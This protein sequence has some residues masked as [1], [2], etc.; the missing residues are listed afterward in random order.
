[1]RRGISPGF[2]T[3]PLPYPATQRGYVDWVAGRGRGWRRVSRQRS[4]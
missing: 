3:G 2:D 4:L 1:V